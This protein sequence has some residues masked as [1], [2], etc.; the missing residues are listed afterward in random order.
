MRHIFIN[1]TVSEVSD[2]FVDPRF[3]F[4]TEEQEAYLEAHPN[5]PAEEVRNLGQASQSISLEDKKAQVSDAIDM[6]A[7]ALKQELVTPELMLEIVRKIYNASSDI[8]PMSNDSEEGL[9][10]FLSS[11]DHIESEAS[12]LHGLV[13][14]ATTVEEVEQA[15]D[16]KDFS[17]E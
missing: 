9:A 12:R 16:S 13:E 6:E 7:Q 17:H 2:D 14:Q 3:D 4:L 10:K 8:Q 1:G 15:W 11:Y 5:A